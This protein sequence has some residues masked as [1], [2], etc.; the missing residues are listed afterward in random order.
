MYT[1]TREIT[2]ESS[3]CEATTRMVDRESHG[4]ERLV[5]RRSKASLAV[6]QMKAWH[7]PPSCMTRDLNIEPS[8]RSPP[9]QCQ[10]RRCRPMPIRQYYALSPCYCYMRC[11][12][13][14]C[15]ESTCRNWIDKV[16]HSRSVMLGHVRW[17]SYRICASGRS[18]VESKLYPNFKGGMMGC[19]IS[20][21]S[22]TLKSGQ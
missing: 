2:A 4:S 21:H 5:H 22:S 19:M 10:C 18:D 3:I 14:C 1:N 13:W 20:Q 8:G 12:V 15:I 9:P 6:N 11:L 17:V 16:I 7:W